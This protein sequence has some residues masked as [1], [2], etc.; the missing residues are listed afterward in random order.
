L[1]EKNSNEWWLVIASNTFSPDK[2]GKAG[3][4]LSNTNLKEIFERKS[5]VLIQIYMFTIISGLQHK[6]KE[7]V[8]KKPLGY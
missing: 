1:P 7:R 8:R 5:Y 4:I 3:S 2:I 6:L